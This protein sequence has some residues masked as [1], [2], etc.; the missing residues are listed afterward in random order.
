MRYDFDGN[1]DWTAQVSPLAT[2]TGVAAGTGGVYV[3]GLA[4]YAFLDM[5]SFDG[6]LIWT[7]FI[8]AGNVYAESVSVDSGAVYVAGTVEISRPWPNYDTGHTF[9]AKF[10]LNGNELWSQ[11]IDVDSR[12]ATA[13]SVGPKGVYVAEQHYVFIQCHDCPYFTDTYFTAIGLDG[14]TLWTK[15]LNNETLDIECSCSSALSVGP[16]GV[17]VADNTVLRAPLGQFAHASFVR[18][19][20]FA[21]NEIWTRFIPS[22]TDY[23]PITWI[24]ADSNGA[25]IAGVSGD[26][27]VQHLDPNGN[28]VWTVH[29]VGQALRT[30]AVSPRG[31][32]VAGFPS[33]DR[34]CANPSCTHD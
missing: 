29:I 19:Y 16:T 31:V 10:D 26:G 32:F 21:G 6:A 23:S 24:T 7:R 17:Y 14:N 8:E 15:Q 30:V 13:I 1:V 5:Y 3:V 22:W 28:E 33:I 18:K 12:L 25:Y 34:L 27:F 2:V 4:G 11:R 9:V 20:D